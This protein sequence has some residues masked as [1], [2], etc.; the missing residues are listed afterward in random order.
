MYVE[1][2]PNSVIL[3]LSD[4]KFIFEAIEKCVV[5]QNNSLV[6]ILMGFILKMT[7]VLMH[8]GTL[9]LMLCTCVGV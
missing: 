8:C 9:N 5:W 6:V 4:I 1:F 2:D 7:A 3:L